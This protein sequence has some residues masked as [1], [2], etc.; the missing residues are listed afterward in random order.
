MKRYMGR[1]LGIILAVAV[2]V[3]GVPVT[4]YAAADIQ[5]GSEVIAESA[6]DIGGIIEE[7][8]AEEYAPKTDDAA[9][10][11]SE[12]A[13]LNEDNADV[14]VASENVSDN[15][16]SEEEIIIPDN[17]GV[18]VSEP[19]ETNVGDVL[20]TETDS[21][22][23]LGAGKNFDRYLGTRAAEVDGVTPVNFNSL[24]N[25]K[26]MLY[27]ISNST[28]MYLYIWPEGG[29][30][31]DT[32]LYRTTFEAYR[33]SITDII[34]EEGIE[35]ISVQN[36]FSEIPGLR[37]VRFP[38]TL[39]TI[40]ENC[41]YMDSQLSSLTFDGTDLYEIGDRAFYGCGMTGISLPASVADNAIIGDEA[42]AYT[43]LT[44]ITIPTG[45]KVIGESAFSMCQNLKTIVIPVSV[46]RIGQSA[47]DAKTIDKVYY[48]GTQ[49]QWNKLIDILEGNDGW[50][51]SKVVFGIKYVTGVSI[52]NDY[53][54]KN[55][56]MLSDKSYAS[57]TLIITLKPA[58]AMNKNITIA[59]SNTSLV[60]VSPTTAKVG[61]EGEVAVILTFKKQSLTPEDNRREATITVTTQDG[62]YKATC[63][64]IIKGM[65]KLDT[66]TFDGLTGASFSVQTTKLPTIT[67]YDGDRHVLKSETSGA[68]IFYSFD[69]NII[70][71]ALW[72]KAV[73]LDEDS[74]YYRV[75][76][77]F[78]KNNKLTVYEC[79]DAIIGGESGGFELPFDAK[80]I[81][82]Y[83]C[84]KGMYSS[85]YNATARTDTGTFAVINKGPRTVSEQGDVKDEDV[86][87]DGI[88]TGLWVPVWQLADMARTRVYT[89]KAITI[90][91]LRVYF[92]N[93]LLNKN[94]DYTLTYKRNVNTAHRGE[95]N[96]PV[97]TVKLK[98]NYS[99][100]GDFTFTIWPRT[101]TTTVYV[102]GEDPQVIDDYTYETVY[103]RNI[104]DNRLTPDLKLKVGG[105][106][107]TMNTD[108]TIR[109]KKHGTT[110]YYDYIPEESSG[111]YD[112]EITG[113][114]NYIGTIT[115]E[116]AIYIM[117]DVITVPMAD[118]S[119]NAIKN[120]QINY[121]GESKRP[122]PVVKYRKKN[123]PAGAYTISYR[124]N[125]EA[126]TGYIILTGTGRV[127]NPAS[128]Y[129]YDDK[130]YLELEDI[131]GL[132][133]FVGVKMVPFTIKGIPMSKVN[134]MHADDGRTFTNAFRCVYT[135]KPIE[136]PVLLN[137]TIYE[138]YAMT[139]GK[140]YTVEYSNNK[141]AGKAKITFTGHGIYTGK[142]TRTFTI[143]KIDSSK[144][145][146]Y[147]DKDTYAYSAS[148][149][150]PGVT[151]KLGDITLKEKVDYSLSYHNNK[152]PGRKTD[153]KAPD[154]TVTMKGSLKGTK[155]VLKFNIVGV[156][157]SECTIDV[158]DKVA[159]NS[160]VSPF[161]TPTVYDVYGLKLKAG[162]DYEKT[163]TYTYGNDVD[164][165]RNDKKIP[166]ASGTEV[167]QGDQVYAGTM[168]NVTVKGMGNYSGSDTVT[169]RIV[170]KRVSD[171]GLTVVDQVYTGQFISPGKSD[172]SAPG[173]TV[174][175]A[176]RCYNIV[177]Y[178]ENVKVGTGTITVQGVGDY[179]GTATLKFVI[180]RK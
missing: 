52:D 159:G 121:P 59:S 57:E 63:K 167:K 70:Q 119:V 78:T 62:G 106:L 94:R 162:V 48:E 166:V 111:V 141:K 72:D 8:P 149:V 68:Q 76:E 75:D 146:A 172:I 60:S 133:R 11:G 171:L 95:E 30:D 128:G 36:A 136:P 92:G 102:D 9:S 20:Q 115:I 21:V 14:I 43:K 7:I 150:K 37:I 32:Q 53:I 84:K 10:V 107:L 153:D 143:D 154:V 120:Q 177:G 42:F 89:G 170:K 39:Q 5:T 131:S 47:I 98:G 151:V 25:V 179:G 24:G 90:P 152:K 117:Q 178:G 19:D 112:V 58:D 140:D 161:Q 101:Y 127:Y 50:N 65:D 108:Y 55:N 16:A 139:E 142:T 2:T 105:R 56:E 138:T 157:I 129:V 81:Y 130:E 145:D 109:F 44:T 46:T 99:G 137:Y 1:A 104:S 31:I 38:S 23:S 144:I 40:G 41:F 148:G 79:T 126:G 147:L 91:D 45:F 87:E 69:K 100:S 110:I 33:N 77:T 86:P 88:P 93:E 18:S 54:L 28:S 80:P 83:V 49:A 71:R 168:I 12:I 35:N 29:T 13:D 176:S 64:A 158:Q 27:T 125:N 82:T 123:V 180:A 4:G 51:P 22:E 124:P 85:A 15:D 97:V 135:G 67:L 165:R 113:R 163:F 164:I 61:D 17:V 34:F 134:I 66:A 175:E 74:G 73:V 122:S 96:C 118:A 156:N 103:I 160:Y 3:T 174:L 132:V 169:Y 114:G 155:K 6:S 173:M 26:G 116:N